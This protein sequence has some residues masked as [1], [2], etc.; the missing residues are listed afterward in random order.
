MKRLEKK[1]CFTFGKSLA[2][3]KT[4]RASVMPYIV[5]DKEIYF[6]LARD[7]RSGD[8]TDIGGGVKKFECSLL[9]CIRE[10]KEETSG[11]YGKLYDNYNNFEMDVAVYNSKMSVLFVS[12]SKTFFEDTKNLFEKHKAE[13]IE[14]SELLWVTEA[15]FLELLNLRQ[16]FRKHTPS[17]KQER[18]WT[19][20]KPF[21]KDLLAPV[22]LEHLKKFYVLGIKAKIC[23]PE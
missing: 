20:I 3:T 23:C 2:K 22:F 15:K 13:N 9:G 16:E 19:R 8:L 14:V 21:Y 5:M 17:E 10:F 6:L 11:I 18:I 7:K 12:L 1:F 4:P